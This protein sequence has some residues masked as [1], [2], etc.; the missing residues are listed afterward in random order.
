MASTRAIIAG[1]L[2]GAL[3]AVNPAQAETKWIMASG[4]PESNFHTKNIRAF[5]K[6]VEGTTSV[7]VDLNSNDSLIKLDAIKTALQRG[8]VQIGEIRL[9][10]YGNEDPMYIL[11]G[12]PFIAS[13]YAT[14]WLLKDLQ[15]EYFDKIFGK[16]GLRILYYTPWP[17]QGFYTK[18][19]VN[20]LADFQGKK[21]RIYSTAT[22]QMGEML[23]FN[24]T[25]LPFAEIPQAFSTG[26][27]ESLFT[28]PQTGIDI[29]AWDNTKYFTYAGAILS[30]NAIVVSEK[31]FAALPDK[32]QQAILSAAAKAELR[33][34]EMSA[35]TTAEQIGILKKNGMTTGTAPAEIIA[36]M[37]DVGDAMMAD[38]RKTASP[39]A[40]AILDRYLALR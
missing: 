18:T 40:N 25:I 7:R 8:Q 36:K 10:V 31:A 20:G 39:E 5:I 14:A 27:I 1:A 33:G 17:G 11:A 29:Q 37:K 16:A 38:W 19:P 2:F 28:S 4:F 24:A 6:E 21:L 13:D 32:E 23:G 26:L 35:Q 30:K 12:L 15:K 22:R 34:W 3:M 9:G